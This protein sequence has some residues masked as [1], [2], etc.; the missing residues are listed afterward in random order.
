MGIG[1]FQT[2]GESDKISNDPS[3]IGGETP[4]SRFY[5]I[6]LFRLQRDVETGITLTEKISMFIYKVTFDTYGRP[7]M[8]EKVVRA[9]EMQRRQFVLNDPMFALST[10][11][12]TFEIKLRCEVVSIIN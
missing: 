11:F 7:V 12:L 5:I 2:S 10:M 4:H 8:T 6:S 9:N 1:S 3:D